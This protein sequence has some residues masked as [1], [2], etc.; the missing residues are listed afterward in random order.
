MITIINQ[1][2]DEPDPVARVRVML[3][4][5]SVIQAG[6]DNEQMGHVLKEMDEKAR[7]FAAA[8]VS[9]G[10]VHELSM[11]FHGTASSG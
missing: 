3:R 5:L 10:H 7:L 6:G 11:E 9:G 2:A 8:I 1:I 4:V